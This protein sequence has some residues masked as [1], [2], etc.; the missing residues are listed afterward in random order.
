[1]D[2][3]IPVMNGFEATRRIRE[4]SAIKDVNII[5]LSAS[6]YEE[7]KERSLAVGCNEFIAK[8]FKIREL[9]ECVRTQVGLEWVYRKKQK[10]N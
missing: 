8:P 6:V 7:D 5:A 2:L 3:V 4:S 1:M 10:F 9:L